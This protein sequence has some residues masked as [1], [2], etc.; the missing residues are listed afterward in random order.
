MSG[1]PPK[2][3]ICSALAHVCFGPIADMRVLFD[4][5]DSGDLL[6]E[7]LGDT[8]DSELSQYRL[9]LAEYTSGTPKLATSD[10]PAMVALAIHR[11][12]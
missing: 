3:D 7:Q 2:A 12:R 6:K 5:L 10:I 11:A 4:H 9:W 1:L 8:Q